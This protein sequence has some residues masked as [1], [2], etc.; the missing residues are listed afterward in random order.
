MRQKDLHLMESEITNPHSTIIRTSIERDSEGGRRSSTVLKA[1]EQANYWGQD[2]YGRSY[3]NQEMSPLFY[4][5]I[6]IV[7][8]LVGVLLCFLLL[9]VLM[10]CEPSAAHRNS[11]SDLLGNL[12][13]VCV[14]RILLRLVLLVLR[15]QVD[16]R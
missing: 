5:V 16:I 12:V 1:M 4:Q 3:D 7:C 13:L 9:M 2:T 15:L 8:L 11:G 6:W 14:L 10:E